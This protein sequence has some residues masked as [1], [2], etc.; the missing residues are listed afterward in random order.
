M[1]N[2][3]NSLSIIVAI[4][5]A[6]TLIF[7]GLF[8][9]FFVTSK[10]YE[11][12]LENAYKK[13]FYEVVSNINDL[14]VDLS[15]I[16]ATNDP[17][18]QKELLNG[19]YNTAILGVNNI[20]LLPI[21]Y[22]KLSNINNF[23]NKMGG[24]SY[25]LLLSINDGSKIKD[26]DY[27][28]ITNLHTTVRE[29][30]YDLNSYV[31]RLAYDYNILDD[32]DFKDYES[33][34]FS[35]G[36]INTESSNSKV[37][38]LIYDGP[39]SDSVLN[40]EI[41]GLG[42]IE[43]SS[44]Q[45]LSKL[46]SLYEDYEISFVNESN[47]KFSTYNY[48]V[49]RDKQSLYVSVSKKGGLILTITSFGSGSS[50]NDSNYNGIQ[51]AEEFASK[52]GIQNM[53]SVWT[54][55]TGNIM[56]VNLAPIINKVIYYSDLIKVKVDL[57]LGEVIGWEATNYAT[58]NK[59]RTFTTS[60]SL[61]DAQSKINNILDIKERNYVIIPDKYVG[62]VSAY[63]FICTWQNY[64]YYI[65]IDSN[66]GKEANILRVINTTNGELLL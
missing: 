63:E 59:S 17:S 16:V 61:N 11:T 62:E 12:Q 35:A 8:I 37:P 29:I 3:Q 31:S 5:G 38:T 26:S 55:T 32:I 57:S 56:Y 14:E 25:S 47:G 27:E 50:S 51:V 44:D 2:N 22:S 30:Q 23:L 4:L 60:I 13:N 49:E 21:T 41:V 24:F 65:Y 20:N 53:Y 46:Q 39:F 66:T 36:I 10:N 54:Q 40:K 18:T 7:L 64:T 19:I 33:E 42:D 6:T 28:Q 43:Y 9:S 48:L 1:K 52:L 34:D 45:V 58:N 15:K